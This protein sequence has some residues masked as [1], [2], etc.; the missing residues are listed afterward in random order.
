MA[1]PELEGVPVAAEAV[2][3]TAEA[4][5]ALSPESSSRERL[6]PRLRMCVSFSL[7]AM[8][9]PEGP[10]IPGAPVPT[11]QSPRETTTKALS[12]RFLGFRSGGSS[13]SSQMLL[14]NQAPR[15]HQGR[16]P[17]GAKGAGAEMARRARVAMEG[18][19]V[20]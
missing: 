19:A 1:Q 15:P 16:C 9:G 5:G 8:A 17:L 3:A 12:V 7:P 18:R 13:V 10:V 2:V 20:L 6:C 4:R 14:I 11:A